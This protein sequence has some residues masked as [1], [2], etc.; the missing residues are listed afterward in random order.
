MQLLV[1]KNKRAPHGARAL[2]S[3]LFGVVLCA[4]PGMIGMTCLNA[5]SKPDP[6][7]ALCKN[8]L[9]KHEW[10]QKLPPGEKEER[11]QDCMT[12]EAAFS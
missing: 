9:E 4:L 10:F 2:M 6:H 5:A 12:L 3:M 8:R 1:N 11:I 7:R